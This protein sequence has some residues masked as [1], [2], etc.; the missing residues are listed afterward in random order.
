[1][2]YQSAIRYLF[3]FL[4]FECIPFQY[5]RQFNLKRMVF[6]LDWFGHP[7]HSFSSVLVAGTKGKG[8]TANFLASILIANGYSTGLFSSPHLA[9]PRERIRVNQR[10]ISKNEFAGLV[11][12]IRP[13]VERKKKKITSVYG[14]ITFFEIFTLLT[15]LYFKT[16]RIDIGV[17]EVG[18]GGRLDA[19]NVLN[20]LVSVIAPISFDHEEHLGHTLRQIAGEKAAIIRNNGFVVSGRQVPEA[21][22]VIQRQIRKQKANAYFLGPSF[23]T[24]H[25]TVSQKGSRFDF[26]IASERWRNFQITL[27]GRFQIDNAATALATASILENQFGLDL[28]EANI[29]KGLKTAFW[30]GR[31]EIVKR[32]PK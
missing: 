30:P 10:A 25:E 17:F 28:K 2:Q 27:P 14:P 23:Q 7:E 4:N 6:L 21:K 24:L 12:K 16:K 8:S 29:K 31:F 13:I 15:I 11:A 19:T 26:K 9:D 3:S 5:Q 32:G 18:L 20:P 22:Q 1:M